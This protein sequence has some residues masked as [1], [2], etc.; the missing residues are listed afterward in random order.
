MENMRNALLAQGIDVALVDSMMKSFKPK[1]E[2]TAKK[3]G[4]YPGMTTSTKV[5]MDVTVTTYCQCCGSKTVQVVHMK[6]VSKNS[7]DTQKLAASVCDKCPEFIRQ[8]THEELVAMIMLGEKSVQ[9]LRGSSVKFRAML[10]KTLTP[11][12]VVT[13]TTLS[14]RERH[15]NKEVSND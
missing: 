9:E 6:A 11:E 7:P 15:N 3:S 12:A 8:F 5:D 13:F 1:K 10:A 2:K 4:W 14:D